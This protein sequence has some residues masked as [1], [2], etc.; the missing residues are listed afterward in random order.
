MRGVHN[1]G[2]EK[3]AKKHCNRKKPKLQV[4]D[5]FIWGYHPWRSQTFVFIY[6]DPTI[7]LHSGAPVYVSMP[8]FLGADPSYF[9]MVRGLT[10]D[11]AWHQP[12]YDI[13]PLTGVSLAG[14]RR[15]QLVVRT[16]SLPHFQAFEKFPVSYLPVMWIDGLALMDDKTTE[17]FKSEIQT[18][19][20]AMNW[21]RVGLFVLSGVFFVLTVTLMLR[22]TGRCCHRSCCYGA[23]SLRVPIDS[24]RKPLIQPISSSSSSNSETF[25]TGIQT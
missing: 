10:P 1:L 22:W 25:N 6:L 24:E 12:F 16:Q 23:E 2:T 5:A 20:D 13:H 4:F 19:M 9:S 8:H 3:S 14:S 17:L 11:V 7:F 18:T 21:V 15:Y